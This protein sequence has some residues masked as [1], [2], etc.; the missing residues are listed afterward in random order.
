MLKMSIYA[1][2]GKKKF[3]QKSASVKSLTNFMSGGD[4][5]NDG[6]GNHNDDNQVLIKNDHKKRNKLLKYSWSSSQGWSGL[7]HNLL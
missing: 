2:S 3:G 7:A 1:L 5:D 6:D 4:G